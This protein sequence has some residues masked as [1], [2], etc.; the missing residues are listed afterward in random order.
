MVAETGIEKAL[1][2]PHEQ[3]RSGKMRKT[4]I[5]YHLNLHIIL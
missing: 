1:A 3:L 4:T 5:F 2:I